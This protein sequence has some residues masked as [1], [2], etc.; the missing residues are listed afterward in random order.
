MQRCACRGNEALLKTLIAEI[1]VEGDEAARLHR[2]P[3]AGVR[4]VG[5][6]VGRRGLEP[7]TSAVTALSAAPNPHL[8]SGT[9]SAAAGF[10]WHHQSSTHV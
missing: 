4:I 1:R 10:M 9:A 6:L 5:A 8:I 3:P 2:L 7:R